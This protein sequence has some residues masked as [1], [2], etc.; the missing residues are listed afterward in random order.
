MSMVVLVVVEKIH[1]LM[2]KLNIENPVLEL[3]PSSKVVMIT[4][5]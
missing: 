2:A 5:T 1:F 4:V 3:T